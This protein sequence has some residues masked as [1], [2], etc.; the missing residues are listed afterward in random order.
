MPKSSTA[1]RTPRAASASMIAI[2]SG[3]PPSISVS[4]SSISKRVPTCAEAS[5]A[6]AP[7]S[8]GVSARAEC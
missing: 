6:T 5:C 2:D 8:S 7:G 3:V 4:V 1:R